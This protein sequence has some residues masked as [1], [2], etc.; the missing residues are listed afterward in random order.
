MQV[1]GLARIGRDAEVRFLSDGNAVANVSLAFNRRAKG[2][3]LTDW[4]DA[5]IWGKRAEALA[6]YLLKGGLISVTLDDVHIET[7]QGKNGEGHK[8]VGTITQIELAG[9][10]QAQGAQQQSAPQQRQAPAPQPH[11]AP[12]PAPNFSDM[13]DDIPF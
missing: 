9:G 13:D 2:E 1:F 3:K 11:Q 10:G 12:K 5:S 6:P 4:V 8:L 7:Y